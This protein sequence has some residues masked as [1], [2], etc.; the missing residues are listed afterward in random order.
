MIVKDHEKQAHGFISV[1]R[2]AWQF[3]E[4]RAVVL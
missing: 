1:T 4:L 2:L 3:A